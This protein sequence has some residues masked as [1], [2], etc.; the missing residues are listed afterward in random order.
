M[1]GTDE[2]REAQ[3]SEIAVSPV[4]ATCLSEARLRF[5]HYGENTTQARLQGSRVHAQ[6]VAPWS[7]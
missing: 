3:R 5:E 1:L 2:E 4:K 7:F 6:P